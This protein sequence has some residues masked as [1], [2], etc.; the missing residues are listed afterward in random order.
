MKN[1]EMVKNKKHTPLQV[2]NYIYQYSAASIE[3]DNDKTIIHYITEIDKKQNTVFKST[4]YESM[5]T[6]QITTT[7]NEIT[8]KSYDFFIHLY[9]YFYLMLVYKDN[10]VYIGYTKID[11]H[12]ILPIVFVPFKKNNKDSLKIF[13]E[14]INKDNNKKLR[15]KST[16]K[17][18]INLLYEYFKVNKLIIDLAK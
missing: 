17:R 14:Y 7:I 10:I 1:K 16:I 5:I 4:L 6:H 2:I 12:G 15:I 11:E 8:I 9:N 3:L 13:F 18:L